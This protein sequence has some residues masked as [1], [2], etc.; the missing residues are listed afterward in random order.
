M[1]NSNSN[2]PNQLVDMLVDSTLKKHGVSLDGT[3]IDAQQKEQ[4]RN[5]VDSLKNSVSDLS[6]QS[7]AKKENKEK[8]DK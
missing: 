8:N 7:M 2:F 5:L 4:L 6:Q 3:K 1:A